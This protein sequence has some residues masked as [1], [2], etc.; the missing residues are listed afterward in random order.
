MS[1]IKRFKENKIKSPTVKFNF[2]SENPELEFEIFRLGAVE[3]RELQLIIFDLYKLQ[4]KE[5]VDEEE[6]TKAYFNLNFAIFDKLI[7]KVKNIVPLD[8]NSD[9]VYNKK[10]L[11]SIKE[12][13]ELNDMIDFVNSFNSVKEEEESEKNE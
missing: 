5:A 2:P 7:S 12:T 10:E 11:N 3:R 8:E 6:F 1:F 4:E 9:F 13:F